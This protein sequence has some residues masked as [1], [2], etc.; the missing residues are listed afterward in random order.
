MKEKEISAIVNWNYDKIDCNY[1]DARDMDHEA[2][3]IRF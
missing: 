3:N 1:K 2:F